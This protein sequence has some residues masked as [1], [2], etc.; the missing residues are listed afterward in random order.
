MDGVSEDEK[1]AVVFYRKLH[2]DRSGGDHGSTC[3]VCQDYIPSDEE[4]KMAIDFAL[5]FVD[6][7][8]ENK[9]L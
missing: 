7:L 3:P 6:F 8:R 5:K 1:L 2:V 9:Q 4:M